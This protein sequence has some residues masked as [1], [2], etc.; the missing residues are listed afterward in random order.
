MVS[1]VRALAKLL[2]YVSVISLEA[3]AAFTHTN[4]ED[5][6]HESESFKAVAQFICKQ[7]FSCLFYH[8][9]VGCE[10]LSARQLS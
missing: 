3:C 7:E 10:N 2:A 4:G 5:R 8:S 6:K 9:T 1:A